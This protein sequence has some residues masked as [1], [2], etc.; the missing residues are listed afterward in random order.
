M[1]SSS[2]FL[3]LPV[4]VPLG[5]TI[6]LMSL[7]RHGRLQRRVSL[8]G[9]IVH[10]FVC[11]L[12]LISVHTEGIIKIQFGG[13]S[14]PFGIVFVADLLSAILV[15]LTG[16]IGACVL[17][18]SLAT[19]D[20]RRE[21]FGYHSLFHILLAGVC[22]A[23]L[24]GDLFNMY[25]WFEVMLMSS[26]VLLGLGGEHRQMSGAFKYVALNLI[27]SLLFLSGIGLLYGLVGTL[28]IADLSEKIQHIEHT[29]MLTAIAMLFLTA[30]GIK[31]AVFPLFFWLPESYHTPPIAVTALFA[32]LLTKVGV[33]ALIRVFTL[34]FPVDMFGLK[35]MLLIAAGI[36]MLT[37]IVG[38][39]AQ[40]D[41][42]RMLCYLLISH[43]G[44]MIMG[45]GL[46]TEIAITGSL[47][48]TFHHI[49]VMANLFLVI[50]IAARVSGSYNINLMGGLYQHKA[51]ISILFVIPAM[52]LAGIPPLS[53]FWPK[54]NLI[55]ASIETYNYLLAG[56]ALVVGLLT[57][58][59]IS[60]VWSESFWKEQETSKEIDATKAIIP[61]RKVLLYAPV[62]VLGLLTVL[63]GVF[64][65]QSYS[66][67]E[68][69]SRQLLNKK[70]YVNTVLRDSN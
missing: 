38:A 60:R 68:E 57:L 45:L 22:G 5:T 25:V 10:F 20:Q 40:K 47:F 14:A 55:S 24:T 33:Y 51:L 8:L 4:V 50:G 15:F 1:M 16:L 11:S 44:Y 41:L 52:G 36:T 34:V 53:G 26:F 17:S 61:R 31:A 35:E 2:L 21:A 23:F 19:I 67:S 65:G 28:N 29:G 70:Q 58:Y 54:V 30:F 32:G 7:W 39:I 56:V 64:A 42:R 13:W 66:F 3:V 6:I 12:L 69:S 48:Y 37:G 59:C 43:I 9:T 18:F 49:I 27:S 46:F 62:V 63:I